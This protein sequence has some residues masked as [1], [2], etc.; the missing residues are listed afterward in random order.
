MLNLTLTDPHDVS[1]TS[2]VAIVTMIRNYFGVRARTFSHYVSE[3]LK[4]ILFA[5]NNTDLNC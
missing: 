4:S 3:M 1:E 2:C 5:S